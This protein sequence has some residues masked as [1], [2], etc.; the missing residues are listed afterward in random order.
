M[1]S[2]DSNQSMRES[3]FDRLCALYCITDRNI[4]IQF[5]QQ[6]VSG[7]HLNSNRQLKKTKISSIVLSN[8]ERTFQIN[9][10]TGLGMRPAQSF[11]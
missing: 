7:K 1:R 5:M 11:R 2:A 9:V 3:W 8:V 4:Y 10:Y 6:Y